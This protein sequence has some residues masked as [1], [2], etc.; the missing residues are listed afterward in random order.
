MNYEYSREWDKELNRRL[1]NYSMEFDQAELAAVEEPYVCIL[2]YKEVWVR[3]YP[4]AFGVDY[5]RFKEEGTGRPSKATIRR[6]KRMVDIKFDRA[7]K[8]GQYYKNKN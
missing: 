1:D 6:L 4:Y 5:N 7:K 8:Y 3:N 2:N